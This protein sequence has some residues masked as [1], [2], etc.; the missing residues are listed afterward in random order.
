MHQPTNVLD[1]TTEPWNSIKFDGMSVIGHQGIYYV[2]MLFYIKQWVP[3]TMLRQM[4][5]P[6]YAN[7]IN[8]QGIHL[9]VVTPKDTYQ[10]VK[11]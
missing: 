5:T 6:D 9:P 11:N 7:P 10:N 3:M 1:M 4:Q 8:R 2:R